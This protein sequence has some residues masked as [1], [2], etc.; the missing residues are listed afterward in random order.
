MADLSPA[1]R[2]LVT[3]MLRRRAAGLRAP[4]A[5]L[6][7]PDELAPLS[8]PQEQLWLK[9]QR[10]PG[11]PANR[12]SFAIRMRRSF[13]RAALTAAVQGMVAAH[14]VLR[15]RFPATA[16]SPAQVVEAG[17]DTP[18]DVVDL[19]DADPH[20]RLRTAAALMTSARGEPFDLASLPLTRVQAL[21]LADDDHVVHW[22]TH[23]LVTDAWSIGLTIREL[24][25][26]YEAAWAGRRAD[27][28]GPPLQYADYAVWQRLRFAAD[29]RARL[30]DDW[31]DALRSAP[32][33]ESIRWRRDDGRAPDGFALGQLPVLLP[34]ETG[35]ALA[36]IGADAG[37]TLYMALLAGFAALLTRFAELPDLLILAP[38][39]GRLSGQLERLIGFFADRVVVRLDMS[40]DPPFTELVERARRATVAALAHQEAPLEAVLDDLAARRGAE[41][42]RVQVMCSVQNAT[43][44]GV[45]AVPGGDSRWAPVPA[46]LAGDPEPILPLYG[47]LGAP[48][49][50][51]IVLVPGRGDHLAGALEF[52]ART[53]DDAAA[54]DV[55]EQF[56]ATLAAAARTPQQPISRLLPG[57]R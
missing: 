47:P 31:A 29:H 39:S 42:P 34:P 33:G 57:S 54:E 26:R 16:G 27:L 7:E 36:A 35:R 13:D 3:Q 53:L 19:R 41:A 22:L 30:L 11:S 12:A 18:I 10:N 48:L 46:E 24:T 2:R 43:Q 9:E 32:A 6:R 40:G 56:V 15:T 17:C 23:H 55:R 28:V 45:Q 1:K 20:E 8:F 49:D 50:L 25:A 52:N 37:A 5:G 38:V 51:S 21:L 14:E 4:V 44:A